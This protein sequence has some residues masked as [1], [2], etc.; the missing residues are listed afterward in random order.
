MD[1]IKVICLQTL[2]GNGTLTS[3][4]FMYLNSDESENTRK[5]SISLK[6]GFNSLL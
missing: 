4:T 6:V 5:S 2:T 1:R 3:R